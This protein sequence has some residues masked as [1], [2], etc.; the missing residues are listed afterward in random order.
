MG[1][2]GHTIDQNPLLTLLPR[3]LLGITFG[4]PYCSVC[5]RLVEA[6]AGSTYRPGLLYRRW[7]WTPTPSVSRRSILA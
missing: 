6:I 1:F 4:L 5:V 2:A 7:P 3:V